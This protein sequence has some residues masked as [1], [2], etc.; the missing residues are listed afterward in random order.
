MDEI[1]YARDSIMKIEKYSKAGIIVGKNLIITFETNENVLSK[2]MALQL[3]KE[4]G[5]LVD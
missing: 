3:L 5:L 4:Y 2:R 1:N